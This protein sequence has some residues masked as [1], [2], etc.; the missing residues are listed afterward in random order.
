MIGALVALTALSAQAQALRDPTRPPNDAGIQSGEAAPAANQLQSVL[1]SS[2]RRVAVIS[3]QAVPL[4][5]MYGE[6]KVVKITETEVVLKKGTET[7]VLKLYPDV[8]KEL[9]KRG[10]ARTAQL[11]KREGAVE[12]APRQEGTK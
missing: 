3:G 4:G 1:I 9:V 6:A 12:K 10:A 11:R 2:G 5:G 7:E 8:D